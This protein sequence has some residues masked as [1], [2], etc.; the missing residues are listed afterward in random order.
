MRG[1]RVLLFL[2][3]TVALVSGMACWWYTDWRLYRIGLDG[4][5]ILKFVLEP[6]EQVTISSLIGV[7]I[8]GVVVGCASLVWSFGRF[9]N[10]DANLD[11][12]SEGG[13]PDRR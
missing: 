12:D 1:R 11:R 6:W 10:A 13:G 7:L 4:E 5:R 9:D 3:L 2:F 8:G